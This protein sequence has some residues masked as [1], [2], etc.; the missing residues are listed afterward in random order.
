MA[1][2]KMTPERA[3]LRKQLGTLMAGAGIQSMEDI[4]S[5]FGR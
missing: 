4:R 1:K 2:R 5:S 3:E